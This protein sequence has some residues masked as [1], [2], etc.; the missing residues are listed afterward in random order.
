MTDNSMIP[1]PLHE[2]QHNEKNINP[3]IWTFEICPEKIV[4][5]YCVVVVI[6]SSPLNVTLYYSRFKLSTVNSMVL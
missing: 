2:T 6:F 3:Y 4:E 1:G 5:D